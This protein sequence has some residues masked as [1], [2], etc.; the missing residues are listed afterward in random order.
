MDKDLYWGHGAKWDPGRRSARCC[1]R[2]VY[3]QNS[4]Q[5]PNAQCDMRRRGLWEAIRSE[6]GVLVD[7][8][9]AL[10]KDT[11]GSSPAPLAT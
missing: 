5:N 9:N 2:N 11:Q 10:I 7:G 4:C 1:G 8:H 6:G 3:P